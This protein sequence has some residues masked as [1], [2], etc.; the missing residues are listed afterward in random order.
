MRKTTV[1]IS[2]LFLLSEVAI[3]QYDKCDLHRV[4]VQPMLPLTS[5]QYKADGKVFAL[6]FESGEITENGNVIFPDPLLTIK[7]LR[8]FKSCQITEGGI[9][10]NNA[11]YLTSNEAVIGLGWYS[12]SS[13]GLDLFS[14]DTC[15]RISS[16]PGLSGYK[17]EA[18]RIIS[19]GGCE[20]LD[21][22]NNIA[23]CYPSVVQ[24]LTATCELMKLEKESMVQ[25]KKELGILISNCVE[26]EF[27][28]T[29]K[30]RLLKN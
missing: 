18:D 28:G 24:K 8:T 19:S 1:I 16:T 17:I 4:S 12:G 13:L 23:S 7:N 20:P 10:I 27:P 22:K 14:T 25:T 6:M 9:W 21:K 26:I 5:K 3:A 2:T 30:A 15:Q 29:Q 11:V